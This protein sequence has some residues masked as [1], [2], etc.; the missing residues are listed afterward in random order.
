MT[1]GCYNLN[2]AGKYQYL[3]HCLIK[4]HFNPIGGYFLHMLSTKRPYRL[5][6][7]LHLDT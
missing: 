4:N 5:G 6:G 2:R 1:T 7:V 3:T